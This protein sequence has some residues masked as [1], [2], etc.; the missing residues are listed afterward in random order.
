MKDEN[1]HKNETVDDLLEYEQIAIVS[2]FKIY[3]QILLMWVMIGN[4]Q[5]Y[6]LH[7]GEVR[8]DF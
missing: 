3:L 1:T 5:K 8:G 7:Y 2:A 4:V 6:A